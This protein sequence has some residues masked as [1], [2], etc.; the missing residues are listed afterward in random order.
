M[1]PLEIAA[2]FVTLVNVWLTVRNSIWCWIWGL[3]SAILFAIV[4]YNSHLPANM[5]LSV[6]FYLPM[7]I[8]GWW[9]WL[10]GGPKQADDLPG[11]LPENPVGLFGPPLSPPAELLVPAVDEEGA[12]HLE[13]RF[14]VEIRRPGRLRA[15][16][17]T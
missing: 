5:W 13:Q 9:V 14:R 11:Q 2:T 12:G 4:F 17:F 1:K 16:A 7:Q 10:R 15:A 3:V 6:G 8:I